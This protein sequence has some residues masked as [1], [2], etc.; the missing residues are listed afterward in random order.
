MTRSIPRA[1]IG[2][3]LAISVAS[4][5]SCGGGGGGGSSGGGGPKPPPPPPANGSSKA[6]LEVVTYATVA[7]N[8]DWA[9]VDV[10][11][12]GN[13]DSVAPIDVAERN[14]LAAI[15]KPGG[16]DI[17]NDWGNLPSSGSLQASGFDGYTT[18]VDPGKNGE[19]IF[20]SNNIYD[21]F[22]TTSGQPNVS[23]VV[24]PPMGFVFNGY[25]AGDLDN[26]GIGDGGPGLF[27]NI[28]GNQ[29]P[30]LP[31]LPYTMG[32]LNGMGSG[33][34]PSSSDEH[35]FIQIVFPYDLDR[36]SLFNAFNAST[37]FLG[38][39]DTSLPANVFIEARWIQH[40]GGDM[41]NTIDETFVHRHVSG[42]AVIGGVTAV[43]Y[44]SLTGTALA[45]IDPLGSNVPV[46]A[47]SLINKP[48]VFTYIANE[49][50]AS[51]TT[52]GSVLV[53]GVI[54]SSGVLILPSPTL[55]P[56]GGRVFGANV[57]VP[58][59]VNDFAATGNTL[60]APM[61]F[62]SFNLTRLRSKSETVSNPYF[63]TFPLN[64]SKVGA[65]PRAADMTFNRGAAIPIGTT[66]SLP[67]IDI[68]DPGKDAIDPANYNK[69]PNGDNDPT[70]PNLISTRANFRIDFDKEVVPNSVGFSRRYTIHATPSLGV[71]FPFNGNSRP[72]GSPASSIATAHLGSPLASSIY[73]AVNQPAGI[74]P[75]SGFTQKVNSPFAKAGGTST[76][77]KDNGQL[78]TSTEKSGNGLVPTL[79]NTLATLPRGVVP[80]DIYPLNQ[81]NRQ[82]Y[83]VETLVEMPPDVVVTVGVCLPGLGMSFLS[84]TNRGNQS[85]SGTVFT[86][87]QGINAVG[88]G[89]SGTAFK[90]AI[91][92]NQT[93]IKVNA[94]P[95][96]LQG[97]LAYGGTSVAVDT[98][99]DGV[100]TNDLTTGGTN[101]CRTFRVG[102]DNTY[103]YVNA[104]VSPQALYL[105]YSSGGAGVLDLSG[106]GYNTNIPGG[107]AL[108][109]T[110]QNY[111]EV[112]RFLPPTLS[113]SPSKFNFTASGQFK[114]GD[115]FRAFGIFGR[116]TS[117]GS[118][119]S[120]SGTESEYAIGKAISTGSLT[121]TPGINEGSSGYETLV[122]SGIT[123]NNPATA[124]AILTD[125]SKVSI[126]RDMQ[127]GDFLDS[128]APFFDPENSNANPQRH[129][130]YN[131]PGQGAIA[132]NTI[133]DPPFPNPP[134]LRFPVG[135]P[136]TAVIFDQSDV[137]AA[138]TLI[139]GNE[140]FPGDGFAY[141]DDS[142]GVGVQSPQASNGLIQL[143]PTTNTSNKNA[144]DIAPL[145]RAGFQSTFNFATGVATSPKFV[146]TGPLPK[147][148][149]AGAVILATRNAAA[150]GSSGSGGL[151]PPI[152]E[153][154]QQ[155]GNFLFAA[156]GVN[157]KLHAINSNTMQVIQSLT[158]PDPY[159]LGM[160]P[161]L[162]R[163]YVSN[164]GDNSLSVVDADP[165]SATFM[166]ELKRIQV[167]TGP[168]AVCVDPDN[169][170]VFVLNYL[171]NTVTIVDV[172][173]GTVRKT[174]TDSGLN[175]PYEMA[176]GM[177]EA[178]N[179]PAFQSGTYH[180]YISN[181]GGNN[182]L[183]YQSGPDGTAGIGFDTIVGKV[184]PN[185]PVTGQKW[186]NMFEPRG[187]TYDPN[188]PLDGFS[189]T[190]G[191]FVAHKDE[192]GKA[193]VT[194]IAYTADTQPGA[195]TFN[196]FNTTIGFGTTVFQTKAQYLSSFPAAAAYAVA[197]PDYNRKRFEQ[198]DFA[199]YFN[200][201]NAGAT[202]KQ[203]PLFPRNSKFPLADNILPT[204]TNGPR[205]DADRLY[206]SISGKIIEVFD[207]ANGTHLKTITTPRD[208]AVMT[209]F[210][211]Q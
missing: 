205:W 128:V 182:V 162:D 120:P 154:R 14:F 47:R 57:T 183:V 62:V 152:Y 189:A 131:T 24:A 73:V 67:S 186:K 84:R 40:P 19:L 172:N 5:T 114:N 21:L 201:L 161:E 11:N 31:T 95:M 126:V 77:T 157:R 209:S 166:T 39:S 156:D 34:G 200:L 3:A 55:S 145:P 99:V 88:L 117:G 35:Q 16:T 22:Q 15:S 132:T 82:A 20:A 6:N 75:T 37:S 25:T 41:N 173:S 208:V 146:Q 150:P 139:Q 138:P 170:D 168:R 78:F 160:S 155:I 130:T 110:F 45:T 44:I 199:S 56:G 106:T 129:R 158:L 13:P 195:Q 72:V 76:S 74:S 65:D 210:F 70:S 179:G 51:I 7:T 52:T 192:N 127:V 142:S 202:P 104:P 30:K 12:G 193:L 98:L 103:R 32:A 143:N 188:V 2:F 87:F 66:T 176:C 85:R 116:Y 64:Q 79:M 54:D 100:M 18:G 181:Y 164:E 184:R 191:C 141:F 123:Q 137:A 169:E 50:P 101:V 102:H 144:F 121:P 28:P 111:V 133:A 63:H 124:S 58:G 180:G 69:T 185:E 42:V 86:G 194:R 148:A 46:G 1:L 94:G 49:D 171:S 115:H 174:L 26:D 163:L 23:L 17:T 91:L 60:A 198:E 178:T 80:C 43:P 96:D 207:V 177:R 27:S 211:S 119:G 153:A 48:N 187:I 118:Q 122:F 197:L 61:G 89:D 9:R 71:L 90:T 135:L 33:V 196:I 147:T 136:H 38:D 134:P 29:V 105:G 59:S 206:L 175:R 113:G 107:A 83:V 36:E 93:V 108:N 165:T 68:L 204:F 10:V 8:G 92:G 97:L 159:G 151:V 203:V 112:S 190:V 140:V 81:N 167:G 4:M 53:N 109:T 125:D 149:T